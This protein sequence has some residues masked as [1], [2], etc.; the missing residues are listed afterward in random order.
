MARRNEGDCEEENGTE[1]EN[2]DAHVVRGDGT[3]GAREDDDGVVT[4]PIVDVDERG[5]GGLKFRRTPAGA[6]GTPTPSEPP[7]P[8]GD[9]RSSPECNQALLKCLRATCDQTVSQL[10]DRAPALP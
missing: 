3:P 9:S 5:T 10:W 7:W 2:G 6:S 8:T 1:H 4:R